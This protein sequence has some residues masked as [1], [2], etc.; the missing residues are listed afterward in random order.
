MCRQESRLNSQRQRG[1]VMI[2]FAVS[3]T[4]LLGFMALVIDLGRTYVVRTE[5]QN[6]ADAA[7]LAGAKDLNQTS[8]GVT[9][10]VTT[11]IAMAGKNNYKFSSPVV[12]TIANL[13][14]GSCPDDSCMVLASTV[15][16]D[17]LAAGK[18][19]LKVDIP[20]VT[21]T[22]FVA[23]LIGVASTS[24]FGRAVAGYFVVDITPIGVCAI[25]ASTP[26]GRRVAA[27]ISDELT[28]Y[29]FRRGV[30]YNLMQLGDL[31]GTSTPY[32]LNP[33]DVYSAGG[34]CSNSNS[35]AATA[36]PY[37]CTGTATVVVKVPG[38]TYGSTGFQAGPVE[39]ALNSRFDDYTGN[40]C[41]SASAPPDVNV[42]EYT[43]PSGNG[44][45]T[46]GNPRDWMQPGA[47]TLPANSQQSI[48]IDPST[49]K[50]VTSPTSSQYGAL[51]SYSR[52]IKATGTSPNAK[53]ATDVNANFSLSD[54]SNLYAGNTADQTGTGYPANPSIPPFP[55]GSLAAPYNT[56]SGSKYFG[57]PGHTGK[58][59]RRTLQV[60]IVDCANST[61]NN[62]NA[63]IKILGVGRFFLTK[64][65]AIPSSIDAE[66]DGLLDPIPP[67]EIRLY[68]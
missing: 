20:S 40:T 36:A 52:A 3:L 7:A 39:R 68:K 24:T 50:P 1:A 16:S 37:I 25:D 67:T 17:A 65:A 35:S 47:N 59:D 53:A 27:G 51:W 46:S 33:V 58:R 32:L 11:A 4:V 28:E 29:G 60:A 61:G 66:F 21:L 38:F 31:A 56:S 22:A 44:A 64:K 19:F 10:A 5:L 49:H 13:S 63:K 45:G 2:L 14:V 41:D 57:L 12:I 42:K 15:T 26:G 23:Q 43:V 30:A 34:P 54:W 62:C 48:S 8:A 18:T 6:A 55:T 9:S